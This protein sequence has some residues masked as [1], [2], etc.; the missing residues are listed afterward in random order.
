MFVGRNAELGKL[1]ALYADDRFECVIIYGRRRIGK[2]SLI[3]EF[4]RDREAIFFTGMETDS[5]ENLEHLSRSI[6]NPP[7]GEGASPVFS[8]YEEALD[9]IH[10]RSREKRL[11][12]AIDEYPYLAESYRGISS[13]LQTWIDHRLK[14][15]KLFLILCGSSMSFMENQVLGYK[16]PLYGRRTAQIRIEPFGFFEARSFYT[17]FF[18]ED[19][20]GIYGITGGVP[21]YLAL[22]N[23]SLN[24]AENIRK[25]F[26]DPSA[27]LFEEPGNLLK[28]EI[29]EPSGYNAILRAIATGSSKNAEIASKVSMESSACSA[30]LKNLIA[31]GIV[32][33]ET[34]ITEKSTRK[35][36]YSLADNMFRFWY[37]FIPGQMALIQNGMAGKAYELVE[38][39]FPSFMGRVFEDICR[40]YLWRKNSV[41]AL[42]VQFTEIGRWW[43]N[44]PFKRSEAEIDIIATDGED[45]IFCECKWTND[46]VA[47]ADL[48]MLNDRSRLLRFRNKFLFLFAK[49][50]FTENCRE[51]ASQMGNVTLFSLLE[52]FGKSD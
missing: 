36:I 24:L 40:E 14:N 15:S 34:P 51:K 1:N 18:P 10:E 7:F 27:Y 8:S 37:R 23:D 52:M 38:K 16:S 50:G 31:L 2:T 39:E 21:Q 5:G 46:L 28:Q 12:L 45:A 9:T 49:H 3:R 20:A 4:I 43:G 30:Y 13:L 47:L 29:R 22:M 41:G 44:D 6:M 35:T 32:K 26:L 33:K 11:I 17:G 48:D 25:N 19:L 42:P